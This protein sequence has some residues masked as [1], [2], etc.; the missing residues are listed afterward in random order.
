MSRG[1]QDTPRES[2]GFAYMALTLFGHLFH[3][4]LLPSF[5]H[6]GV[7]QP[8]AKGGVWA[9]PLSLTATDGIT[10]VFFSFGY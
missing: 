8:P 6:I 3:G 5:S 10:L 7:L 4:V 2:F 9:V 1:T